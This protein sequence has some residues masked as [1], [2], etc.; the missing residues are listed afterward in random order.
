[1][2]NIV[3][4]ELEKENKEFF[5]AYAKRREERAASESETSQRIH[6]ILLE[7]SMNKDHNNN[8]D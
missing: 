1:M 8:D 2:K 6:N 4:K 3:W 7:S 5:E